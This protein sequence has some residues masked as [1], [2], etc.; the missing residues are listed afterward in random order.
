VDTLIGVGLVGIGAICGGL[1]ALPSKF[2]GEDTPW[3]KIWGFFFL[4]V[5]FT[6][7]PLSLLL[8]EGAWQTWCAAGYVILFPLVFGAMWGSGSAAAAMAYK[9]IGLSLGFAIIPGIQVVLGPLVPLFVEQPETILKPEGMAIILGILVSLFGVIACGR[10]GILRS[11]G[12]GEDSEASRDHKLMVKGFSICFLAGVLCSCL[13]YAFHFSDS[14]QQAS[15]DNHGNSKAI[16]T[17]VVWVPALFGGGLAAC[18]YC[19]HL[20]NKNKT[21]SSLKS[22]GTGKV[23][24][25]AL[26]MAL[27]HDGCLFFY[28]IGANYLGKM[29]T[30][31][32]FGMLFCGIMLTGSVAGFATGEWKDAPARSRRF[33]MLGMAG[34]V[35]GV[36]ILAYAN[37]L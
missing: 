36:C 1:F 28:G 21:W 31:V 32:G 13:N 24:V 33:I 16:A 8:V 4:F 30:S 18:A 3:E 23:I 34:L 11:K 12:T 5:A 35:L 2:A 25:L 20:L 26:I 15:I 6:I 9:L 22:P 17:I 29:G 7:P 14:I 10:A 19:I 37:T 27:L